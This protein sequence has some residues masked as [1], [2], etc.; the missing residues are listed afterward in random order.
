MSNIPLYFSGKRIIFSNHGVDLNKC[1][2][3]EELSIT[4]TSTNPEIKI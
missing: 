4:S 3:E 1:L 2:M